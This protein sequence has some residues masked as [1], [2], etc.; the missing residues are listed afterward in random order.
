MM[1]P[2]LSQALQGVA[3]PEVFDKRWCEVTDAAN[4]LHS[5]GKFESASRLYSDAYHEARMRFAEAWHGM[6]YLAP[7]ATPMMVIS[8]IN[9]ARNYL[10]LGKL[11]LAADQLISAL[12]IFKQALS[13]PRAD[14]ALK[15]ACV[16]HLPRL[17]TFAVSS[18]IEPEKDRLV[19]AADEARSAV[20]AY[21]ETHTH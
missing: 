18:G 7:H 15:Q 19:G 9:A 4:L 20:L 14:A 5:K 13:S 11:K 6:D 2:T 17:I 1:D 16:Q 10:K 12:H 8:A 21:L 3:K